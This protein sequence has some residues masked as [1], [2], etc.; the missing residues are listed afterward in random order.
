MGK[1]RTLGTL[2]STGQPLEGG[3]TVVSKTAIT[4]NGQASYEF[5]DIPA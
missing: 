3:Q 4:T 5:T 1:T 2:V